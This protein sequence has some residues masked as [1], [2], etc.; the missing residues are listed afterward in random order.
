[1]RKHTIQAKESGLPFNPTMPAAT[2]RNFGPSANQDAWRQAHAR[3]L[4]K[5]QE[6]LNLEA[7][8]HGYTNDTF[9][10]R[11]TFATKESGATTLE[12]LN[13]MGTDTGSMS[14]RE[15]WNIAKTEKITIGGK[16]SGAYV[17]FPFLCSTNV[18]M[19][20]Y[21]Q[22][23]NYE[24]VYQKLC[25]PDSALLLDT[26]NERAS[27]GAMGILE[28]NDGQAAKGEMS[29]AQLSVYT[30]QYKR[31]WGI[32]VKDVINDRMGIFSNLGS[33]IAR[34]CATAIEARFHYLLNTPGNAS[35]DAVAFFH[36]SAWPTG[37][38]NAGTTA[39]SADTAG[40]AALVTARAQM[41]AQVPFRKDA[42]QTV[43]PLMIAPR[44]LCV[45]FV[46]EGIAKSLCTAPALP[47]SGQSVFLA[48]QF[49]GQAEPVVLPMA[50]D[51]TDWFLMDDP[52]DL[53]AFVIS[54]LR[55]MTMPTVKFGWDT[56]G[57][58]LNSYMDADG[59]PL[60]PVYIEAR[61]IFEVNNFDPRG[62]FKSVV[63]GGT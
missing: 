33:D 7:V 51:M 5:V 36:A 25:K 48:N 28:R 42:A 47:V 60:Y 58:A 17:D 43:A 34:A 16:E 40:M 41:L 55:G 10:W 52:A 49:L 31:A 35:E 50:L 59:L 1:M 27:L 53:P 6:S 56:G 54:Y 37:H 32:E 62:A 38:Y 57:K 19:Q 9:D 8:E 46:L 30:H 12:L 22:L 14:I 26:A 29:E 39:L 45:P 11:K 15:L 24:P 44:Y 61:H 21:R 4:L 63:S 20:I 2:P 18:T 23:A 13:K 3:S